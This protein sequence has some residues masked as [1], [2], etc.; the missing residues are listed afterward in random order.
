VLDA[1]LVQEHLLTPIGLDPEAVAA[2]DRISYH[3]RIEDA[4]ADVTGDTIA[5]LVRAPSAGDAERAAR[6]GRTLPQKSTYFY[7]KM[8]DGFVFYGLDDCS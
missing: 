2:T 3:H 1:E 5:V 7:P 8:L 6:A 4:E